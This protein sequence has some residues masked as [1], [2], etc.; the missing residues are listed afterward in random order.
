LGAHGI[1]PHVDFISVVQQPITNGISHGG[2]A[3]VG[4]PVFN[5]TL[6]GNNGGSIS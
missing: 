2:V 6:A 5:G 3:D 1:T 4:M